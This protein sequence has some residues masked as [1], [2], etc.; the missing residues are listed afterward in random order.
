MELKDLGVSPQPTRKF[1]EKNLVKLLSKRNYIAF[2]EN[3]FAKLLKPSISGTAILYLVPKYRDLSRYFTKS[4]G[5]A[6]L[7]ACGVLGQRPK[8]LLYNNKPSV[9]SS[10]CFRFK[11]TVAKSNCRKKMTFSRCKLCS[12][13]V[14][15]M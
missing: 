12:Q 10:R 7:K 5:Q 11:V 14:L 3:P 15:N 8:V 13:F 1:F 2:F 9:F 4:L 6:F